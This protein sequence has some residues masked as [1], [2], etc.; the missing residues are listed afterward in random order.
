MFI[1]RRWISRHA[2]NA[3]NAAPLLE[4]E[5]R[6][7]VNKREKKKKKKHKVWQNGNWLLSDYKQ[8]IFND[9]LSM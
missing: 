9:H 8:I 7:G 2:R 4:L 6:S 3:A 5:S 1:F